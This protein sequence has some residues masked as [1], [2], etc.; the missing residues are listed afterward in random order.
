[1]STLSFSAANII[2][3]SNLQSISPKETSIFEFN[4]NLFRF[5]FTRAL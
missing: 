4:G 5:N 1:M 2:P 3:S